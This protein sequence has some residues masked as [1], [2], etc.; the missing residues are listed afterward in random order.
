[1]KNLGVLNVIAFL[2]GVVFVF[3]NKQIVEL[4]RRYHLMTSGVAPHTLTLKIPY[5]V[6]GILF[7][8]LSILTAL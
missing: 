8:V 4:T 5:F 3:F 6:V 7:I 2:M 1:M